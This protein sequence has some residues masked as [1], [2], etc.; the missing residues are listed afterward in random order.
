[1]I[2]S[3]SIR[4][5]T[6][7]PPIPRVKNKFHNKRSDTEPSYKSKRSVIYVFEDLQIADDGRIYLK[8]TDINSSL[9]LY[10]HI[11]V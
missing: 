3:N 1:M 4:K 9:R 11:C 10:T 8:H 7:T 5:I 6:D 2:I